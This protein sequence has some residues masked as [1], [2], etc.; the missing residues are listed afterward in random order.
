[1]HDAHEQYRRL[2]A[3][4]VASAGNSKLP[5]VQSPAGTD[6]TGLEQS[7][8]RNGNIRDIPFGVYDF[9]IA[10]FHRCSGQ[11]K[12]PTDLR[13]SVAVESKLA[14][15][16]GEHRHHPIRGRKAAYIGPDIQDN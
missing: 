3:L 9:G 13:L 12:R 16:A 2:V 7:N 11:L 8:S 5:R 6:L 1:M 15:S 14:V 10:G 4:T